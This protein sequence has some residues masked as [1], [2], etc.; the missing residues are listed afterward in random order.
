MMQVKLEIGSNG[1]IIESNRIITEVVVT[2]NRGISVYLDFHP[3]VP[4]SLEKAGCL[5]QRKMQR[6]SFQRKN[7]YRVVSIA[8]HIIMIIDWRRRW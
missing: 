2:A 3:G 5:H 1:Y 7:R 8:L 4:S 6:C